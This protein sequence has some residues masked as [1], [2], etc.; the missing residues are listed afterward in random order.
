MPAPAAPSGYCDLR[1]TAMLA[2]LHEALPARLTHLLNKL[3]QDVLE[4]GFLYVREALGSSAK[5]TIVQELCELDIDMILLDSVVVHV[6]SKNILGSLVTMTLV[7]AAAVTAR[8]VFSESSSNQ[9]QA[10]PPAVASSVT[11]IA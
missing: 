6:L 4:K 7:L 9:S 10:H 1:D 2:S 3:S 5:Q 11:R 8:R